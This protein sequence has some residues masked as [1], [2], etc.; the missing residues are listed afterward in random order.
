M[1]AWRNHRCNKT[2]LASSFVRVQTE[3]EKIGNDNRL[4]LIHLIRA[5]IYLAI[6]ALALRGHDES[7]TSSNPGIFLRILALMESISGDFANLRSKRK[8]KSKYQPLWTH[9]RNQKDLIKAVR[10]RLTAKIHEEIGSDFP[11]FSILADETSDVAKT[12]FMTMSIRYV[13]CKSGDIMERVLGTVK[14][15]ETTAETIA[16]AILEILQFHKLE[17]KYARGQGYDGKLLY[18][19]I[20]PYYFHAHYLMRVLYII[21]LQAQVLCLVEILV[22]QFGLKM[23]KVASMQCMCTVVVTAST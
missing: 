20:T 14:V 19:F 15:K 8:A 5:I 16:S 6:G 4:Y 3:S 23:K 7:A 21:A 12:E 18:L 11:Y 2:P 13:H 1:T 22:W 17:L 10:S 9:P